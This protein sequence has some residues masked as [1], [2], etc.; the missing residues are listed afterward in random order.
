M[1]KINLLLFPK[2]HKNLNLIHEKDKI[3]IVFYKPSLI[4]GKHRVVIYINKNR[5]MN[6]SVIHEK[7]QVLLLYTTKKIDVFFMEK[8]NFYHLS[9]NHKK[10]SLVCGNNS[11]VIDFHKNKRKKNRIDM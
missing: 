6:W 7:K 10:R 3:C 4:S 1:E 2:T 8:E 5:K 9:R 11:V